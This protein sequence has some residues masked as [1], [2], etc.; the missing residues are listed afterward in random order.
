MALYEPT[1]RLDF[2]YISDHNAIYVRATVTVLL[3]INENIPTPP[4]D[5][6]DKINN[7]ISIKLRAMNPPGED[8]R[9]SQT[10]P[11]LVKVIDTGFEGIP[12]EEEVAAEIGENEY[13]VTTTVFK[14]GIE[15]G[16]VTT[17]SENADIEIL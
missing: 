9:Y 6:I 2:L 11:I 17:T 1:Q 8:G 13:T 3:N 15:K 16:Q 12:S 10:M 5:D 7:E 14:D 4:P